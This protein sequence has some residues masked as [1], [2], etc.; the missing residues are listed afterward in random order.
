MVARYQSFCGKTRYICPMRCAVALSLLFLY[1][2]AMLR[3]LS[4]LIEYMIRYDYISK[5]LCENKDVP[6]MHCNGKC[7]LSKQIKKAQEEETQNQLPPIKIKLQ[8]YPIALM[9]FL[10]LRFISQECS[11]L[12]AYYS[13]HYFFNSANSVFHPPRN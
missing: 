3:P 8:D 5:V 4:P 10:S 13:N 6:K 9:G 2:V 11:V 12:F 1:I 7:Y